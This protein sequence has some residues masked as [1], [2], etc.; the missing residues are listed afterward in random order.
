MD[1]WRQLIIYLDSAAPH[2]QDLLHLPCRFPPPDAQTFD[3]LITAAKRS[4]MYYLLQIHILSILATRVACDEIVHGILQDL[5]VTTFPELNPFGLDGSRWSTFPVLTSQGQG[6][7]RVVHFLLGRLV[8]PPPGIHSTK[9]CDGS[10]LSAL[11]STFSVYSGHHGNPGKTIVVMP[12]LPFDSPPIT[13]ASLSLAF[14]LAL[15]LETLQ[16]PWPEGLYA[17]GAL[18]ANGT[19]GRVGF[20]HE[21]LMAVSNGRCMLVAPENY[22][23]VPPEFHS[24]PCPDLEQA[25]QCVEMLV[26]ENDPKQLAA[27]QSYLLDEERFLKNIHHIPV[28]FFK[29][30]RCASIL[31]R[32]GDD[33]LKWLA[34]ANKSLEQ[35]SYDIQRGKLLADLISIM[36]LDSLL[37]NNN[38]HQQC[39]A[40]YLWCINR[41]AFANHIGDTGDVEAWSR[42]QDKLEDRVTPEEHLIAWNHLFISERFNRYCFVPDIPIKISELIAEEEARNRCA[43]R[44]NYHLGALY[45]TL[46]Q[47][48]GFC[49]P[50]M[51]EILED[52]IVKAACAFNVKHENEKRRLL[53]YQVHAHLDRRDWKAATKTLNSYLG[54][55]SAGPR[56]W[57]K[58]AL[59]EL[60]AKGRPDARY[61]TATII[62]VL[63]DMLVELEENAIDL[64]QRAILKHLPRHGGHPWQLILYNLARL[65]VGAGQRSAVAGCM[66]KMVKICNLGGETMQ[67]M[68]L[69][70]YAELHVQ[71]LAEKRHYREVEQL[72][73]KM[74]QS[75][76]LDKDHFAPLYSSAPLEKRLQLLVE[77]RAQFFPFTY[78]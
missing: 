12:M 56:Q 18:H 34:D 35:C 24:I 57:I 58:R 73:A 54:L 5:L 78:R 42:L 65:L 16:S 15:H 70:A 64:L 13:G 43:V 53:S 47:N 63:A 44:P 27:L 6:R 38:D 48:A 62:R 7:G 3:Q 20:L 23:Q 76:Y 22:D 59:E 11:Q 46:A 41:I 74:L 33:P 1:H 4:G 17:S 32:I 39:L 28:P 10:C 60:E 9:H 52:N 69:L 67:T 36:D 72:L 40:G 26:L 66:D 50:D 61:I 75:D 71:N 77:G 37:L 29:S 49:G 8:G 21:K 55:D 45:G 68:G 14:A 19:I 25:L 2:A 31:R 51:Y 30:S